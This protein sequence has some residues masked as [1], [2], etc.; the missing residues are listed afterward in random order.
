MIGKWRKSGVRHYTSNLYP[1]T[2]DYYSPSNDLYIEFN[3]TWTHGGHHFNPDNPDDIKQLNEWREK[4]IQNTTKKAYYLNAIYTWTDLDVRKLEISKQNNLNY[5]VFWNL[6][7][8]YEHVI[9][10]YSDILKA[11]T[12]LIPYKRNTI[13]REFNFYKNAKCEVLDPYP[14][15]KKEI[16]KYFQQDQLFKIEQNI[17]KNDRVKRAKLIENRVKYLNKPVSELTHSDI[18]NGFKRSGIYYGYSH[19]NPL[20]FKWFIQKYNIKTCYDPTGGWG[21][22]VLGGLDLDL[23]VYNDLSKHTK[24]HVDEIVKFFHIKNVVT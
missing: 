20:W 15:R 2:C 8:I 9:P 6:Y 7:D 22:R 16:I 14:P 5:L 3:G 24:E 13:D 17:W 11:D 21:D 18:L 12:L 4:S 1:F 10:D 23:Y 19:F